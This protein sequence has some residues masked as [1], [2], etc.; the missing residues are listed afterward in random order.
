M[1]QALKERFD[2][3]LHEKSVLTD[4]L[5]KVEARTGVNR[6]YIALGER[7][8]DTSERMSE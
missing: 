1:A 3:F 6:T 5:A 4:L 2:S 8:N 7:V